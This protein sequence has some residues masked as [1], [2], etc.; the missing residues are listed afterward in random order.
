MAAAACCAVDYTYPEERALIESR[1]VPSSKSKT[2]ML[3]VELFSPPRR[4]AA[5]RK[6]APF[7]VACNT[8]VPDKPASQPGLG[9]TDT[10]PPRPPGAPHGRASG[11]SRPGTPKTRYSPV[12]RPIGHPYAEWGPNL[13]P[14]GPSDLVAA[15]GPPKMSPA[16]T[17]GARSPIF[18]SISLW[19]I[20]VW[21][22]YIYIDISISI[23]P[24]DRRCLFQGASSPT[25][26]AVY[27]YR[28]S[29]GFGV[30]LDS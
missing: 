14:P 13:R 25:Q 15:L 24:L 2:V 5:A 30:L 9:R 12:I 7:F 3:Q 4:A 20:G 28:Y 19:A 1:T 8:P 17:L 21:S 16:P 18:P 26:S 6:D 27:M 23:T 11:L 10:P 22:I 29:V